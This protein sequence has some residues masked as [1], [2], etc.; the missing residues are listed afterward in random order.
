MEH[1]RGARRVFRSS[2]L[3]VAI[4]L[5]ATACQWSQLGSDGSRSFDNADETSFSPASLATLAPRWSV[6]AGD[7]HSQPVVAGG[8]VYLTAADA[9]G[10]KVMSLDGATGVTRWTRILPSATSAAADWAPAVA[11]GL[12]FVTTDGALVALDT[13][14]G[15]TRW[16]VMTSTIDSPIVDGDLVYLGPTAFDVDTGA[17]RWN[18]PAGD[19]IRAVSGGRAIAT[20][21]FPCSGSPAGGSVVALDATTGAQL[22]T[23]HLDGDLVLRL[24]MSGGSVLVT[25]QG[26]APLAP[27]DGLLNLDAGSGA[28]LAWWARGAG[29]VPDAAAHGLLVDGTSAEHVADGS[30]AW[31]ANGAGCTSPIG[32]ATVVVAGTVVFTSNAWQVCAFDVDTGSRLGS[33]T[34]GPASDMPLALIAADGCVYATSESAGVDSINALCVAS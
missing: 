24:M 6:A 8:A 5:T 1:R 18:A 31:R 4:A 27:F 22:W 26:C 14:S 13:A 12:V 2:I 29:V 23:R 10:V 9:G 34:F 33:W 20:S 11:A 15:E 3:A 19:V 16:S 7:R 30:I 25:P 21:S 17:V 32:D 28:T